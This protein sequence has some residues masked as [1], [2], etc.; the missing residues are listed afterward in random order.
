MQP[1]R[2]QTVSTPLPGTVTTERRRQPAAAGLREEVARSSDHRVV[3]TIFWREL[4]ELTSGLRFRAT[5]LLIVGLMASS[6]LLNATRF[7]AE[8]RVYDE[9]R[10]EYSA[11]LGQSSQ[12]KKLAAISH[13]AIK[14][15]WKLAFL[16]E[17]GQPSSSN[18]YL[19]PLSPWHVPKVE[20]WHAG[21]TPSG[22]EPLDWLFIIRVILSLL[23][24]VLGYDAF[25][26]APQR[27]TLGVVLSYPIARWQVFCT[28][29]AAIWVCLVGPFLL[30]G[31]I[32]LLI[33][34]AYGG[35]HFGAAEWSKIGLM[36]ALGLWAGFVFVL[37]VLAVSAAS[38]HAARSL[39]LLALIWVA[40]VVVIPAASG[41]VVDAASPV[42]GPPTEAEMEVLQQR[43]ER[44]GA[45][46]WR[47]VELARSD[48]FLGE[49]Q[50]LET[51]EDRYWRQEEARRTAIGAQ[52]DQI[53]L[54]HRLASISPAG[55][56]QEVA[57]RL[58]GTGPRRDRRFFTQAWEHRRR[59]EDFVRQLD[60]ADPESPHLHFV[61][62]FMSAAPYDPETVPRFEMA[63]AGWRDGLE[64]ARWLLVWLTLLTGM[65]AGAG[66]VLFARYDLG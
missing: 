37:T 11:R 25:C 30:G 12:V 15:P 61:E 33:L 63:E 20:S 14:P 7:R 10:D 49:K 53:E 6:A 2:D 29:L 5:W 19:Q 38:R 22:A 13:P 43:A 54:A 60:L 8:E 36:V 21:Y 50:S 41:V 58:V 45:G 55:L 46:T 62:G 26:G 34:S 51:Q 40:A 31:P 47:S 42:A 64:D 18:V 1:A 39:A 4:Q 57:E 23:A 48:G 9:L 32:S 27:A 24:V 56:I 35:V 59:L 28:K 44:R 3:A 65:L 16:V 66:L 52:L 17:G